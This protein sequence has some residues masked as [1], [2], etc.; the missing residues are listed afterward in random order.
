[1]MTWQVLS[2][3]PQVEVLT[4][5][6]VG[7][8]G[9]RGAAAAGPDSPDRG[10]APAS[11]PAA[12]VSV[13]DS[14]DQWLTPWNPESEKLL[15]LEILELTAAITLANTQLGHAEAELEAAKEKQRRAEK[16]TAKAVEAAAVQS[17]AAVGFLHCPKP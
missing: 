7:S 16:D 10:G 4:L 1:M 17:K 12:A 8:P 6:S 3:R 5:D 14:P 15:E 2:A 13:C 9:A 11:L